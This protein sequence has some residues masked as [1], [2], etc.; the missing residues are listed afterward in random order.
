MKDN[1]G[2]SDAKRYNKESKFFYNYLSILVPKKSY[3]FIRNFL[4]G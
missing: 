4:N 2:K 1:D 3:N